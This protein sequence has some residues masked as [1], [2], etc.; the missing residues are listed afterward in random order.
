MEEENY[1]YTKERVCFECR[2]EAGGLDPGCSSCNLT[3]ED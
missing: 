3:E 2:R 1:E